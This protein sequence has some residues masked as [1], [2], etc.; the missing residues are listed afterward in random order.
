MADA[1]MVRPPFS[2]NDLSHSKKQPK[3]EK[4]VEEIPKDVMIIDKLLFCV[5]TFV[6]PCLMSIFRST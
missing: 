2:W 1:R 5:N 4:K 3:R 6:C